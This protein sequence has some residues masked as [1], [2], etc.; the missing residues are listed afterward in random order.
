[1]ERNRKYIEEVI[2]NTFILKHS[3]VFRHLSVKIVEF[4][5]GLPNGVYNVILRAHSFVNGILEVK[6]FSSVDRNLMMNMYL[7]AEIL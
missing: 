4:R 3:L 6:P 7:N 2:C 5:R 1:M